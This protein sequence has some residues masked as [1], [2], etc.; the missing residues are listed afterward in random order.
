MNTRQ[1][2]R[3][4]AGLLGRAASLSARYEA[5]FL[6][7]VY[8][9]AESDRHRPLWAQQLFLSALSYE[10]VAM[11]E[12]TPTRATTKEE[13]WRSISSRMTRPS[14]RVMPLPL[15]EGGDCYS[16]RLPRWT[17]GRRAPPSAP[18]PFLLQRA[19]AQQHSVK[20]SFL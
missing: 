10:R 8:M 1:G 14:E 2:N 19:M 15:L 18:R 3:I 4:R 6:P 11:S 12:P 16:S 9:V 20:H 7:Q 5:Q 13:E 17:G